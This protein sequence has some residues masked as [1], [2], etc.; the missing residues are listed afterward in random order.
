MVTYSNPPHLSSP[1]LSALPNM[2]VLKQTFSVRKGGLIWPEVKSCSPAELLPGSPTSSIILCLHRLIKLVFFF[3]LA[4]DLPECTPRVW[5]WMGRLKERYTKFSKIS[6]YIP[7]VEILD[8]A[9]LHRFRPHFLNS[10]HFFL[11][12]YFSI[13]YNLTFTHIKMV[14]EIISDLLIANLTVDIQVSSEM[15]HSWL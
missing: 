1:I 13:Y 10:P 8:Q 3:H 12:Y 4:N 5:T 7:G 11:F 15:T 2:Q 9:V 14:V 6:G